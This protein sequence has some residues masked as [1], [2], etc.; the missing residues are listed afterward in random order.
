[1]GEINQIMDQKIIIKFGSNYIDQIWREKRYWSNF[2]QTMLAKFRL[3]D[4]NQIFK[5]LLIKLWSNTNGQLCFLDPSLFT[6]L[7]L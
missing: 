4:I 3:M 6:M 5:E 1:M 2:E 7:P